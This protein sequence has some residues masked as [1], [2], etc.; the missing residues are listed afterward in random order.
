MKT[1]RICI[2]C[3]KWE[4]GG[5]ESFLYNMLTHMDRTGLEIDLVA[6]RLCSSVFTAPLEGLGIRFAELSGSLRRIGENR[7]LF[8]QLLKER[9]YDAVHLNVFQGLSL[10]LLSLAK[11]AGVPVRIAHSHGA[12]LRRSPAK[13]LKLVIHALGSRCFAGTATARWACSEKAAAFLF[14]PNKEFLRVPNAIET[15][16]FAFDSAVRTAV[17]QELGLEDCFV[18]GHV[19]RFDELKNQTFLVDLM[20]ATEDPSV[21]LLLVGDGPQRQQIVEKAEKLGLSQRIL[22]VGVREDPERLYQAMDVFAFPS[23]S[24]GLG[25]AAVEAQT[26]GLPTLCSDGVPREA[27]VTTLAAS[28]PLSAGPAAWAQALCALKPAADRM[29][30]AAMVKAAGFDV[31]HVSQMLE[32]AYRGSLAC[33]QLLLDEEA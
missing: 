23:R 7:R 25:I 26:A 16:R 18:I 9:Q 31:A 1:R 27:F 19:G 32:Q 15:E 30:A 2:Y 13:A 8:S 12:G 11:K 10:N 21:R 4:S 5:I 17:R 24:E 29:E 22:F 3:Q 20:A 14:G 33:S 28:M 6:D